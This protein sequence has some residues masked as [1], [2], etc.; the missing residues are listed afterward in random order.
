MTYTTWLPPQP[1]LLPWCFL[2]L[3][4]ILDSLSSPGAILV[5]LHTPDMFLSQD[6]GTYCFP[7]LECLRRQWLTP[8]L[9][10]GLCSNISSVITTQLKI[11]IPYPSSHFIFLHPTFYL[12]PFNRLNILFVFSL[13]SLLECQFHKAESFSQ[14]SLPVPRPFS[15]T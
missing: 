10:S 13:P 9:H 4:P 7:C 14:C 12:P 15:G 11:A 5:F 2:L 3:L 8:S 1:L 6:L